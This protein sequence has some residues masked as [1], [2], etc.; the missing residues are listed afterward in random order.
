VETQVL[1]AGRMAYLRKEDEGRLLNQ[2]GEV[3]KMLS[4]L[5]RALKKRKI[6]HLAPST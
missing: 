6:S 2:A 4:G 3:S 5:T 1:I